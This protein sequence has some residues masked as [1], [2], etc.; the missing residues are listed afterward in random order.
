MINLDHKSII[1]IEAPGI[2]PLEDILGLK[3][4]SGNAAM[5]ETLEG[6]M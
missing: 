5:F 4:A 6:F 3:H 1:G 2:Q